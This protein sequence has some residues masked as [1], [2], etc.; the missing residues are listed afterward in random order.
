[1]TREIRSPWRAMVPATLAILVMFNGSALAQGRRISTFND[2]LQAIGVND[3]NAR[4]Y[5]EDD[6]KKDLQD[7]INQHI[8]TGLDVEVYLKTI[9]HLYHGEVKEANKYLT[10]EVGKKLLE[11]AVGSGPGALL[12]AAWE[13]DKYVWTSIQADTEA[14]DKQKLHDWMVQRVNRWR[15]GHDLYQID[16]DQA[17]VQCHKLWWENVH[18]TIG[19]TKMNVD[20]EKYRKQFFEDSLNAFRR[21]AR[22]NAAAREYRE[23]LRLQMKLKLD[24]IALKAHYKNAAY[25]NARRGLQRA[26]DQTPSDAQI[27]RYLTDEAFVQQI[28]EE[29]QKKGKSQLEREDKIFQ[30]YETDLSTAGQVAEKAKTSQTS[31]PS[32][33]LEGLAALLTDHQA[34]MTA[35]R[36]NAVDPS[37]GIAAQEDWDARFQ[38]LAARLSTIESE[39]RRIAVS[40]PPENASLAKRAQAESTRIRDA[41]ANTHK[42]AQQ[43]RE[44][45]ADEAKNAVANVKPYEERLVEL[46]EEQYLQEDYDKILDMHQKR[47]EQALNDAAEHEIVRPLSGSIRGFI[48]QVQHAH[49]PDRPPL[50]L[51]HIMQ[52]STDA[53]AAME[54]VR[55]WFDTAVELSH[56]ETETLRNAWKTLQDQDDSLTRQRIEAIQDL[57][58]AY[59][60]Q[61]AL[62][63]FAVKNGDWWRGQLTSTLQTHAKRMK[64]RRT[65]FE[66]YMVIAGHIAE[67]RDAVF[68]E[69]DRE[70]SLHSQVQYLL[71]Q[72]SQL[73][74]RFEDAPTSEHSETPQDGLAVLRSGDKRQVFSE[75]LT[76]YDAARQMLDGAETGYQRALAPEV[77]QARGLDR[78]PYEG[79]RRLPDQNQKLLDE[80]ER[81]I[82]DAEQQNT[83]ASAA[84]PFLEQCDA[85]EENFEKIARDVRLLGSPIDS[86]GQQILANIGVVRAATSQPRPL[87]ADVETAKKRVA[88]FEAFSAAC[89]ARLS[90]DD[91]LMERFLQTARTSMAAPPNETAEQWQA[92]AAL[93]SGSIRLAELQQQFIDIYA[94]YNGRYRYMARIRDLKEQWARSGAGGHTVTSDE[95]P[96]RY[97]KSGQFHVI[98]NGVA[99]QTL[100]RGVNNTIPSK[101][102]ELNIQSGEFD[103]VFSGARKVMLRVWAVGQPK[104]EFQVVAEGPRFAYSRQIEFRKPY[105]LDL[106]V[107]TKDGLGYEPNP[108][109]IG[110]EWR[111]AYQDDDDDD[112][113][114]DGNDMN[115]VVQDDTDDPGG[116]SHA[117]G[118]AP[119]GTKDPGATYQSYIQAYNALTKLMAAGKGDTPEAQQAYIE[120][121]TAKDK[122]EQS[123][124]GT[125]SDDTIEDDTPS[126]G[127][128]SEVGHTHQQSRQVVRL[129]PIADAGVYAYAYRNWNKSNQGA[130]EALRAGWHPSGGA[131]R[132]YLKFDLPGTA[133]GF[134]KATLRLFHNHTGGSNSLSLAVHAV[135]A[136]WV[137]GRDTYHS[138]QNE[139]SATNGEITWVNQPPMDPTPVA[140]F[141]PGRQPNRY[142]DVDI[143]PLVK[144]WLTGKQNHGLTLTPIGTLNFRTPE[145]SYGFCS[146]EHEDTS[147][148]PVLILSA[149]TSSSQ[150]HSGVG[151]SGQA[152]QTPPQTDIARP[153]ANSPTDVHPTGQDTEPILLLSEDFSQGPGNWNV[154]GQPP[155][156]R[157]GRAY[158]VGGDNRTL[159]T[160][161]QVPIEDFAVEFDAY[162]DGE[163]LN[164]LVANQQLKFYAASMRRGTTLLLAHGPQ[165]VREFPAVF[166]P[167][168]WHHYRFVRFGDQMELFLD[169]RRVAS[170]AFAGKLEGLGL[171]GF[172]AMQ[173]TIGLDNIR[174]YDLSQIPRVGTASA[175]EMPTS[176][177]L[178][179]PEPVT[180]SRSTRPEPESNQPRRPI[181]RFRRR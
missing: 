90:T 4:K 131:S 45:L 30:S 83:S 82:A 99:S 169:G 81:L 173:S 151:S 64:T 110:F 75:M 16:T 111:H 96:I 18:T 107:L 63:A 164:V 161:L 116:T 134:N 143:T 88:T 156:I 43:Q 27:R 41:I 89:A 86:I 178:S 159:G 119:E 144:A 148:R 106:R 24:E 122:Y 138:G 52:E 55:D 12:V 35:I 44:E 8:D 133:D 58:T 39:C 175:P 87:V 74:A 25:R 94:P 118:D 115:D 168:S 117:D 17:I 172:S 105:A 127:N 153:N 158:F 15:S 13:F 49:A 21:V 162:G 2:L 72:S 163:R 26:G 66:R 139:R 40:T 125:S 48:E 166:E 59:D 78:A 51:A 14:K 77:K 180:D 149:L 126:T 37:E 123:L 135:S 47:L 124:T 38:S 129:S 56:T 3:P 11:K 176:P 108:F 5:I 65:P 54:D 171:L 152:V 165:H 93:V 34:I 121:K 10:E 160:N 79:W 73:R 97:D 9:D 113:T 181:G 170:N 80:M 20:R 145:S 85:I 104:G 33:P 103:A 101:A 154:N 130:Y 92:R 6:L 31:V 28:H 114:P 60:P 19:N 137:E 61:A 69:F 62:I 132:A 155:T 120:Y 174:V 7:E 42:T 29:T 1:M 142:I 91:T 71:A 23:Q 112:T 57:E 95:D 100:R 68:N 102:G 109:P 22:K 84:K 177:P 67:N 146:R 32:A 53:I 150:T 70:L 76:R 46:F 98:I 147:K 50:P 157:D 167:G 140:T 36:T 141:Q 136:A 128:T 179:Q